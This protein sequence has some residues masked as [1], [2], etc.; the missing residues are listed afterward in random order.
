MT[1]FDFL[2][3]ITIWEVLVVYLL[4]TNDFWIWDFLFA[5]LMIPFRIVGDWFREPCPFRGGKP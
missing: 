2:R 4:I 5:I 1:V 3:Q